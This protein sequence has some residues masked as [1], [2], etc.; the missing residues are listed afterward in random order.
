MI[1]R[2][3]KGVAL[4]AVAT[5]LLSTA[6]FG[7]KPS[8]RRRAAVATGYVVSQ[9]NA[10]GSFP[11][12]SP[13]GSTADA[14]SALVAARRGPRAIQQALDYLESNIDQADTIGEK[15]KLVMA[16]VAGGRD[17]AD[18]GEENLVQDIVDSEQPSGRYGATTEVFNHA[19]AI[20]ALAAAPGADPSSNALTWLV[21]AQ[22]DDGGWQFDEPRRQNEDEHCSGG[23][24]DFFQSDTNTTSYAVQAIAAHPQASAPPAASPFRFFREMR[25]PEKK[26]W[27]YDRGF[28]LTDSNS[29]ALVIQAFV[30][31]GKALPDGAMRALKRL[32]YRLCGEAPGAFPYS[33]EKQDDGTYEKTPPDA[34]ATI[35]AILGLLKKPLPVR[36]AQVTKPAP[37][38]T[39]C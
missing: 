13:V 21:E 25:D 12:F 23:E 26:G 15:A 14:V 17:P 38:K 30:A 22:C 5:L 35:G 18:F 16:A 4:G 37:R 33:Y 27:G 34:G 1:Q 36:S 32:Q 2:C 9:Q 20:L 11:G 7:A 24:G 3:V 19:L 28:R 39:P 6:S 10:D 31:A 29:T 8:L